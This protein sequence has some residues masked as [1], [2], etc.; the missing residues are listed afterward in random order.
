MD[1][2]LKP[3]TE[4]TKLEPG[5]V[6]RRIG[7][8]KD[9]QGS[10]LEFD[11][12][13]NYILINI[14][15]M[16]SGTLAASE[17]V[18]KPKEGDA[19]YYYSSSFA[20]SPDAAKA[21]RIIKEWPLF[22]DNAKLQQQILSFATLSYVPEQIIEMSKNDTLTHLFIPI[23]ERFRIGRFHE[24]RNP[25]RLCNETFL[26]WLQTLQRGNHITYLALIMQQ[27]HHI[28]RFYSIG[29]RPHEETAKLLMDEPFNFSPTNGGH[30]KAMGL[31]DGKKHFI[32]DAGSTYFGRG[33]KT[34]LHVSESVV[35]GLKKVYPDFEFT[36]LAGRGAFGTQQSY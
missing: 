6:I 16:K 29:T 2:L 5:T 11:D 1:E 23:Q 26:Q 4:S 36:P 14:I 10:F 30:I 18:L 27:K 34:P 20:T 21:L 28:P 31:K 8:G 13:G 24:R 15:D 17:G 7:N 32:V 25:E 9:Q 33:V 3:L 35:A 12:E 19:L 22:K